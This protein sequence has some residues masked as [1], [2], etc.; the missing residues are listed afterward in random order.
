[1]ATTPGQRFVRR[2]N[3][4]RGTTANATAA[5]IAYDTAVISEGG[6]SWSSP[7]VTVDEAGLYL[8]IFDI[9]QVQ[10]ASTRAVGTLVPSV[11]ATDQPRFRATH[12]YLRNSGGALEGASIGMCILDLAVNDDVKV[13]NPGVLTPTDAL[14]NY[15]TNV[16]FGGGIQ[17]IRLPANNFTHLE[18]TVDAAEVG[19]SNINTTRPWL[20]SSGTWTTITYN[21]EVND[22]ASLY[23]GTGGDVTL[24]ANTKY[25]VVWGATMYSTDASR[26]TYVARLQIDGNNV[27]TGSSYPRNTAS[28][29]PPICGM[30]L[31]E[32]GV[33]AETLRL[34]ATHETEGGDA[35]T[36]QVS[37]AYLQIIELPSTAEWIHVDNGATDSLATA[38]AG[39][40]TWDDTPLS[41][42]L[43]ADGDADLSLDGANNAVQNDSGASL[44]ILAI[45][46]HRWDRDSGASGLRKSPWT[47]WDNGGSSVGYGVAGAY[48]RGQQATDD[49]FQAHYCSVAAMDLGNGAD[50][51][52]Q[53]ND[54]ASATNGDMGIYASTSRYYLGVQALRLNS[55]A[56]GGEDHTSDV[57]LETEG[58]TLFAPT[59][60]TTESHTSTVPALTEVYA[61]FAPTSVTA[62][63]HESDVPVEAISYTLLAPESVTTEDRTS[64]VPVETISYSQ[65]APTSVVSE[66]HTSDLPDEQLTYSLLAPQSIVAENHESTVPARSVVYS[67]FAPQSLVAQNQQSDVSAESIDYT[68]IAPTSIVATNHTSELGVESISYALLAPT[69][70]TTENQLSDVPSLALSY[71]L[72]VPTSLV[73]DLSDAPALSLSYSLHVPTS[74]VLEGNVSILPA[75]SLIYNLFAPTSVITE[76]VRSDLPLQSYGY[77]TPS[78][79]SLVTEG[80]TSNVQA[81]SVTYSLL[82]PTSVVSEAHVSNFPTQT[83]TYTL[84]P[85][86]SDDG[87]IAAAPL[88]GGKTHIAAF[89][90][91]FIS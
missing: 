6:Y 1:M 77:S 19:T 83:I 44:S 51:S 36:P 52:L 28:Q 57:P 69:S 91:N 46:W 5:D 87:G 60:E 84:H 56:A 31:H 53:V 86:I 4:A 49:T 33:S 79:Q 10:I 21:S 12:R 50:L 47:R 80:D 54:P 3:A 30:Y 9:G 23:P 85:L 68:L 74:E 62:E 7:E 64:V 81:E 58:Y 37:D 11:N 61:L 40:T 13:R 8:T 41:S 70:V 16:I 82:A 67:L 76:H 71:G 18:R 89:V 66:N 39:L 75:Q 17:L 2:H 42:T 78:P 63:N 35:G 24:A 22:D 20:D 90:T 45:G 48:S 88:V 26:H 65:L 73:S 59:S 15:A 38:L 43:R 14:G 34:Q 29:G 55:I 72:F 32:T 27:Q 25:M